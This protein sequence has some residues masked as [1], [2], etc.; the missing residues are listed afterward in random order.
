MSVFLAKNDYAAYA[1][2]F[3]DENIDGA[4]LLSLHEDCSRVMKLTNSMVG[5]SLK[6]QELVKQLVNITQQPK[7][8]N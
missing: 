5:P 1:S 8:A 6:I 3:A 2:N 7:D 4:G